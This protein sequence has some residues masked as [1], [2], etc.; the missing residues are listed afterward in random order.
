[1]KSFLS[2]TFG[3]CNHSKNAG[4]V[5][6]VTLSSQLWKNPKGM[7]QNTPVAL[8]EEIFR[9]KLHFYSLNRTSHFIFLLIFISSVFYISPAF[10][11]PIEDA[12]KY[13]QQG[14]DFMTKG[15][16]KDALDSYSKAMEIYQELQHAEGITASC[17]NMGNALRRLGDYKLAV[18]YYSR[19]ALLIE[20]SGD[21]K[22]QAILLGNIGNVYLD[23][24][25]YQEA[26]KYYRQS[27]EI[28]REIGDPNI[29]GVNLGNIGSIYLNLQD[30]KT[31][32]DFYSTAI[33]L[34]KEAGN[35]GTVGTYLGHVAIIYSEMGEYRQALTYYKQALEI[36]CNTK[37]YPDI[38]LLSAK[39]SKV[40]LETGDFTNALKY[41]KDAVDVARAIKHRVYLSSFLG[42]LGVVYARMGDRKLSN[43]CIEKGMAFAREMK[44][45]GAEADLWSDYGLCCEQFGEMDTALKTY[46]QAYEIYHKLGDQ[47][48]LE[49][50]YVKAAD[51]HRKLGNFDDAIRFYTKAVEQDRKIGNSNRAA[52]NL[53]SMGLVYLDAGEYQRALEYFR[54]TE[55]ISSQTGNTRAMLAAKINTAN[56]YAGMGNYSKALGTFDSVLAASKE[57]DNKNLE[58]S[59]NGNMGLIN[60]RLGNYKKA[61]TYFIRSFKLS[62]E[63]G[64]LTAEGIALKNIGSTYFA[65]QNYEKAL[66]YF[67]RAYDLADR[68]GDNK[69][70]M[71]CRMNLA[72]VYTNTEKYENAI[73]LNEKVIDECKEKGAFADLNRAL[74]NIGVTY[75]KKGIRDNN[76]EDFKKAQVYMEEALIISGKTGDLN[77][78][79]QIYGN[80]GLLFNNMGDTKKA[81]ESLKNAVEIIEGFRGDVKNEE[82]Q[83][84]LS[85]KYSIFYDL[86]IDLLIKEGN[87][88]EALEYAER[89]KARSFLDSLGN[90]QIV[91]KD[92]NTKKMVDIQLQLLSLIRSL[93]QSLPALSEKDSADVRKKIKETRKTIGEINEKIRRIS[94]EY[95]SMI[96][97]FPSTLKDIQSSLSPDEVLVEYYINPYRSY[98]WVV[99]DN[100]ISCVT[101]SENGEEINKMVVSLR[102]A[103]KT[104]VGKSGRKS[105]PAKI[106][107][108]LSGVYAVIFKPLEEKLQGKKHLVIVPHENLH[109]LPFAA[110]VDGDGKFLVEKYSFLMEPSSSSMVFLRKRADKPAGSLLGFALGNVNLSR[111]KTDKD[112]QS[113]VKPDEFR[114][115]FSPLPGTKEEMTEIEKAMKERN[116]KT[117][118]YMEGKFTVDAVE[119][120]VNNAGIIHFA[121]HGFLSGADRGQF[122][123]LVT[124]DGFIYVMD[125]YNWR[126]NSDLVVL[127]ACKTGL[128]KLTG[129]DEVVGLSRAFI[130]AGAD[131][132]LSTLW[133]VQDKASRDLM[134]DFY[135]NILSG[136][137]KTDALRNAQLKLMKENAD[138]GLWAPFV[139]SGKGR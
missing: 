82:M 52:M 51:V 107:S 7:R 18:Q 117:D 116:A 84:S 121:T 126:L 17:V 25:K 56:A 50:I 37:N 21:K 32:L 11:G 133:S 99:S 101:I 3:C 23:Q 97:V 16:Y 109:Y 87:S 27:V 123:G 129:G 2:Y 137:S 86:L 111:E 62:E 60:Y 31:A 103:L 73:S 68:I 134:I 131:N 78:R 138:P 67:N 44:D 85:G 95:A 120:S 102:D 39:L 28:A 104:D 124:A 106:R 71:I 53:G 22:T 139:L 128:G 9:R 72:A 42:E 110:L 57:I 122:S 8:C 14:A 46:Y 119:K 12:R 40:Y 132:L 83:A 4:A 94:P 10:A 6:R 47:E 65:L 64:D 89:A 88:S 136:Q 77:I 20:K 105:E 26:V 75:R 113:K 90:R 70:K 92:E 74:L 36:A 79:A 48:R 127:S 35:A 80:L 69:S 33:P 15:L 115:S 49:F 45:P 13:T 24:S 118:I 59:A 125:I 76:K 1:M 41:C 93:S 55:N 29:E 58:S 54:E 96:S 19:A 66:D 91:P 130:Q 108:L 114:D 63:T 38:S 30:Y 98:A 81:V 34:L 112:A 100:D 43:E 5:G 61:Y 135:K